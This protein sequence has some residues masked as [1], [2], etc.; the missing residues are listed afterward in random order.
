M[1]SMQS[2][3]MKKLADEL[4]LA[5]TEQDTVRHD[6]RHPAVGLEAG[7]HVLHEHEVRLLARLRTPLAET[8]GE[9]HACAAVVLRERRVRK[10]T[11][12]LADL[13]CS[14]G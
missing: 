12:E 6:C 1:A 10:H 3:L 9:L 5:T 13:A 14:P 8:T 7:E 11:V 4:F 2:S